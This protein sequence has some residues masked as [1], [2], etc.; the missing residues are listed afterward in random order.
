MYKP[1]SLRDALVTGLAELTQN[2]GK[3]SLY[4]TQGHIAARHGATLSWVYVYTLEVFITDLAT[5]T[6]AVFVTLLS[7]IRANQID[8]LENPDR[9]ERA[10]TFEA[11]PLNKT[12]CDLVIR[13]ALTENVR[14]TSSSNPSSPQALGRYTLTHPEEPTPEGVV[15]TPQSWDVVDASGN[16]MTTLTIPASY[17][18]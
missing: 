1:N 12:S 11:E 10:M 2:P 16:V 18:T 9:R 17:T 15:L 4:I 5:H 13:L 8:I 7:W 6:D 14:V 3:L